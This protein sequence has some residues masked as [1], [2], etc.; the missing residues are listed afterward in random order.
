MSHII[1]SDISSLEK[2]KNQAKGTLDLYTDI[3]EL[4]GSIKMVNEAL[5]SYEAS[6]GDDRMASLESLEMAAHFTSKSMSLMQV[7]KEQVVACPQSSES[8]VLER[9]IEGF[10]ALTGRVA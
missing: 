3:I 6:Q 7:I 2:R 1:N 8:Q 10:K 4:R 5:A 9:D